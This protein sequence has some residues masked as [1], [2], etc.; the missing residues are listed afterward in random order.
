MQH[1]FTPNT[2]KRLLIFQIDDE[3]KLIDQ[4]IADQEHDREIKSK[5]SEEAKLIHEREEEAIKVINN[6]TLRFTC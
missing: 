3:Q 1:Y 2:S 5:L 6:A 4:E